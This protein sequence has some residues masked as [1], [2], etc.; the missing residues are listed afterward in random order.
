MK[1]FPHELHKQNITTKIMYLNIYLQESCV[2]VIYATSFHVTI[3]S[4]TFRDFHNN[5]IWC[6]II[7]LQRR[8][9]FFL[10]GNIIKKYQHETHKAQQEPN[11]HNS[12]RKR[13][14]LQKS[15]NNLHS[16]D[17]KFI[18][19]EIFCHKSL[20]FDMQIVA[21]CFDSCKDLKINEIRQAHYSERRIFSR[22]SYNYITTPTCRQM[23][24]HFYSSSS[25]LRN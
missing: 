20:Y 24:I 9:R 19:G 4:L 8:I 12:K 16:Y 18:S 2:F 10:H 3:F 15:V 11:A 25:Y 14:T 23:F 13:K 21:L 1:S 6:S 22:S 7:Y 5:Y 17:L